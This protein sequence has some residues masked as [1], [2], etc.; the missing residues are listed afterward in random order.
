MGCDPTRGPGHQ[1]PRLSR[2]ESG[3]AGRLHETVLFGSSRGFEVS[4]I[5]PG[6]VASHADPILT[7]ER[8]DLT[9]EEPR[10]NPAASHSRD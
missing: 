8:V 6:R 2:V 5:E 10:K 7:R 3:R 9:R 1:V 4:R